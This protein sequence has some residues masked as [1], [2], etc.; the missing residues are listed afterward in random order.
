MQ[1][2][3]D[4]DS[5]TGCKYA[6]LHTTSA[7][8]GKI[9]TNVKSES[10]IQ[11]CPGG[12]WKTR[13][14]SRKKKNNNNMEF[15]LS[16]FFVSSEAWQAKPWRKGLYNARIDS[17]QLPINLVRNNRNWMPVRCRN[18]CNS[19]VDHWQDWRTTTKKNTA[20]HKSDQHEH[21]RS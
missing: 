4:R 15:N 14:S 13:W 19:P 9:K 6:L 16:T 8:F 10:Y 17:H 1:I 21:S 5:V 18:V 7:L 3:T 20:R 12:L 11:V 2:E